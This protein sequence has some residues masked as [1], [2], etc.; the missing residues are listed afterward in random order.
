M[1][2]LVI[3]KSTAFLRAIGSKFPFFTI[4]KIAKIVNQ[5]INRIR[6]YTHILSIAALGSASTAN[7]QINAV[8]RPI[9]SKFYFSTI[10]NQQINRVWTHTHI[11][12]MAALLDSASTAN[13]RINSVLE[14]YWFKI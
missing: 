12:A 4:G 11:L 14:N 8:R 1:P 13:Q 7:Q 2:V 6:T 5:H 9:G 10:A 3:N